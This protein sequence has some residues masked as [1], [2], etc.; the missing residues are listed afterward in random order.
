MSRYDSVDGPRHSLISDDTM[1]GHDKSAYIRL[2]YKLVENAFL[3]FVYELK[4]SD[5]SGGGKSAAE[6][7]LAVLKGREAELR[8]NI[9]KTKARLR[10][11]RGGEV[12]AFLDLIAGWDGELKDVCR[13]L[14]EIKA[15]LA[16]D[17]KTSLGDAQALLDALKAASGDERADLRRRLKARIRELVESVWILAWDVD[18]VTRAAEA[19][20]VLRG[21][22]VRSIVFSWTQAGEFPGVSTGFGLPVGGAEGKRLSDYRTSRKVKGFFDSLHWEAKPLILRAVQAEI[23]T[24]KALRAVDRLDGGDTLGQYLVE[25]TLDGLR[26]PARGPRKKGK[27]Q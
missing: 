16:T 14:E 11:D 1:A 4:P 17:E 5:L 10:S 19:Q 15:R 22:V 12:D 21:G 9:D 26:F 6:D 7:A 3:R 25:G 24:R 13:E 23:A 18:K 27:A 20:V 2:P 8:R